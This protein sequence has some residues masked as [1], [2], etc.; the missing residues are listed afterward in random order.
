MT[1]GRT[2]PPHRS[3]LFGG[4]CSAC[5]AVDADVVFGV[6]DVGDVVLGIG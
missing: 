6:L 5:I 1:S 4:L 2:F 3:T